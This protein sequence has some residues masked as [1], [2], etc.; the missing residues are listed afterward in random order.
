MAED[1]H[2]TLTETNGVRVARFSD[3]KIL[4]EL[5]INEIERELD[6]IV[7]GADRIKLLLSFATVEHLSSAALGMLIRLN[8]KIT[9]RNGRLVLAEIS[10]DI[11]EVFKIT[12]LDRLFEICPT[13]EEALRKF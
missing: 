3:R 1:K 11:F 8:Q 6:E 13:T 9:D 7:G 10:P 2:V 5:T 12:R 4:E